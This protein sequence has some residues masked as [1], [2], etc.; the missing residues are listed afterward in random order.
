MEMAPAMTIAHTLT[1]RADAITAVVAIAEAT[2]E[3]RRMVPLTPHRAK[4][5]HCP[6][7]GSEAV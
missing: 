3:I 6:A 7:R 1:L 5:H 4:Y 2:R